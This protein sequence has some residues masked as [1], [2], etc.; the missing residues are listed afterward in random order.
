MLE[1]LQQLVLSP[2]FTQL[3]LQIPHLAL[4]L[5]DAVQ[6]YETFFDAKEDNMVYDF[7]GLPPPPGSKEAEQANKAL[8]VENGTHAEETNAEKSLDESRL[9]CS[10]LIATGLPLN[11]TLCR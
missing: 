10:Q 1:P 3:L 2:G 4:Q 8:I 5:P 11:A 6:D 9:V 7:L